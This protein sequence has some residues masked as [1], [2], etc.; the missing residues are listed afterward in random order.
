[1]RIVL[2]TLLALAFGFL[3][4]GAARASALR[5]AQPATTSCHEM[6]GGQ[7][8]PVQ[9]TPASDDQRSCA[10]HCLSQVNGHASFARPLGPSWIMALDSGYAPFSDAGKPRLRD[11]PEPP[12]PRS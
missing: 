3:P 2:I 11:P 6:A 12:P 7:E 5:H 10:E 9:H 1:V 8:K 4:V